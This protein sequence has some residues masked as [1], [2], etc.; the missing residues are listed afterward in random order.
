VLRGLKAH[1]GHKERLGPKGHREFKE[2]LG[3]KA[4]LV[5]LELLEL[6]GQQAL[7]V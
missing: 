1:R 7:L 3:H 6:L 2:R 5:L 4:R